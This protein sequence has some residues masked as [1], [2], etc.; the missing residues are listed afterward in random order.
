MASLLQNQKDATEPVTAKEQT[1][2][3]PLHRRS[4]KSRRTTTTTLNQELNS[5]K[6][7]K[8]YAYSDLII[9]WT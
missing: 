9:A 8:P 2:T 1:D 4:K 3:Y 7:N 5:P 6:I